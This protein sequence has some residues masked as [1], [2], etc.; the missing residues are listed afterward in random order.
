MK[1]NLIIYILIL[2]S[3][4]SS[5]SIDIAYSN[6]ISTLLRKEINLLENVSN[7]NVNLAFRLFELYSEEIE[8]IKKSENKFFLSGSTKSKME[9]SWYFKRSKARNKAV[10]SIGLK[11]LKRFP[12]NIYTAQ[13]YYTLA[14]NSRDFNHNKKTEFYLLKS[15]HFARDFEIK[16]NSQ[17]A[18]ADYYYNKKQ[19]RK[20]LAYYAVLIK[21]SE[22]E[23]LTK[24][25]LNMA[26]CQLKM[27]KNKQAL[28][29]LKE[30]FFLSKKNKYINIQDQALVHL[31]LFF[32]L[33]EKTREG[34]E[35]F[36]KETAHASEY[37][38]PMAR[39]AGENGDYAG[40]LYLINKTNEY[41]KN[42]NRI[43]KKLQV[44]SFELSFY[45]QFK[46]WN[47][48][49]KA[50]VEIVSIYTQ[51]NIS[52][53]LNLKEEIINQLTEFTSKLQSKLS[54]NIKA[55]YSFGQQKIYGKIIQYFNFLHRIDNGNTD[56]Y[57]YFQAESALANKSYVD[58]YKFYKTV[59]NHKL[60]KNKMSDESL[61]K[62]S[63]DGLFFVLA[64]GE[65]K[66]K[67]Y[68][69]KL[70]FVLSSH[71]ELF[72]LIKRS[73][74]LFPRY[75]LM[76]IAEEKMALS[77]NYLKKFNYSFPKQIKVQRELN[78]TLLNKHIKLGNTDEISNHIQYL[79]S[80]FLK[81][82]KKEISQMEIILGGLLFKKYLQMENDQ[83]FKLAQQGYFKIYNTQYYP[84]SI[85]AK[86]AFNM[87]LTSTM[88][89]EFGQVISWL[90]ISFKLLEAKDLKTY[91][92]QSLYLFQQILSKN[93]LDTT[94][95][96]G[97]YLKPK[98]CK[99]TKKLAAQ[100]LPTMVSLS[101]L[102]KDYEYTKE[103]L[104]ED[105]C[106]D[107]SKLRKLRLSTLHFYNNFKQVSYMQDFALTFKTDIKI[108]SYYLSSL[109][110]REP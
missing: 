110:Q 102:K 95:E 21:N 52:F 62:K 100:I 12:S 10:H 26:W 91:N 72:P 104:K 54:R 88:R 6:D 71:L 107:N 47:K 51:K 42:K 50:T 14:L 27:K 29:K 49:T 101:T 31:P 5:I 38:L 16:A 64:Q 53:D 86:A 89:N 65:T 70:K 19:Y 78:S 1:K 93:E 109:Q 33:N 17:S 23:W 87:A 98:F 103:I 8:V 7:K 35:F 79:K 9:K 2:V 44:K 85:R 83:K 4:Y 41:L 105:N 81:I 37:V 69:N 60:T 108:S 75:I 43:V 67:E 36:I 77:F 94:Y 56:K 34:F 30:V 106:F 48:H 90:K 63:Y 66:S 18:L 45:L 32:S 97:K 92:K 11:L 68:K 24:N 96:L 55:D 20:A 82:S 39:R 80:G 25:L 46:K 13:I 3:S 58:S 28:L 84:Q 76:L 74:K 73:K 59:I 61:L 22:D 99:E 15:L 57:A 40:A